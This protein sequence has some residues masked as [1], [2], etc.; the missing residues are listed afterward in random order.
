MIDVVSQAAPG[1]A[2]FQVLIV[3]LRV[4]LVGVVI[5]TA[6]LG[7]VAGSLIT[8]ACPLDGTCS[9]VESRALGHIPLQM[10][11]GI[12]GIVLSLP[13]TRPRL[14]LGALL[15]SVAASPIAAVAYHLTLVAYMNRLIGA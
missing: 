6:L 15:V 8:D 12:I 13:R 3:L 9:P 10:T 5:L 14:Q 11:I 1:R 2:G 4:L 7:V